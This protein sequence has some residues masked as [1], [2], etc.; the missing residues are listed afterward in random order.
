[1][2][3]PLETIHP[4]RPYANFSWSV[5]APN[6]HP[7]KPF[8]FLVHPRIGHHPTYDDGS[9][10][11]EYTIFYQCNNFHAQYTF[12]YNFHYLSALFVESREIILYL[13]QSAFPLDHDDLLGSVGSLDHQLV[14]GA[15]IFACQDEKILAFFFSFLASASRDASTTQTRAR[16]R[17]LPRYIP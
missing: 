14:G 12:I 11:N 7:K 3:I 9:N 1:M 2:N 5:P 8:E 6:P 15:P 13:I 17:S 4:V 16:V 10:V